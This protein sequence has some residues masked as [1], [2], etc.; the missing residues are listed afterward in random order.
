[1]S[2]WIVLI[3][4]IILFYFIWFV[5]NFWIVFVFSLIILNS[6]IVKVEAADSTTTQDMDETISYDSNDSGPIFVYDMSG[7]SD[8]DTEA[9]WFY[10]VENVTKPPKK[11]KRKIQDK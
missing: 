10:A 5:F 4:L 9:M 3:V 2:V 11:R 7:D 6:F 8:T 1:M